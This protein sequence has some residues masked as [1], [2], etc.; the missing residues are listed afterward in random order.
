MHRHGFIVIALLLAACDSGG[1]AN[2]VVGELASD[3]IE[4]TAEVDEPIVEIAVSEGDAVTAGQKL[5]RQDDTRAKA[6]LAE[7]E[8]ALAGQQARLDELVRGPRRE[9]I[10]SALPRYTPVAWPRRN[11]STE[12]KPR[13]MPP[14]QTT[15]CERRN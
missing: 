5:L 2:R 10:T 12:R 11:C 9:Q 6:R 14:L 3:R 8:A 1:G 13:S 4:L 15:S 7:A